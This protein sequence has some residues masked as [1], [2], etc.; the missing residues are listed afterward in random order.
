MR[1][2]TALKIQN[3][4]HRPLFISQYRL[5]VKGEEDLNSR[6]NSLTF[7]SDDTMSR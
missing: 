7:R 3:E 1:C 5:N 6:M 4:R 2:G